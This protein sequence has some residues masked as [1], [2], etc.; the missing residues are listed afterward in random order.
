MSAVS[1][2]LWVARCDHS[3]EHQRQCPAF[4]LPSQPWSDPTSRGSILAGRMEA[5]TAARAAGWSTNEP[6]FCPQHLPKPPAV[7]L[8]DPDQPV[9][10]D[11]V[12]HASG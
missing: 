6:D 3:D 5:L 4:V 8:P 2:V 12:S 10:R 9:E 7:V 1:T 11:P